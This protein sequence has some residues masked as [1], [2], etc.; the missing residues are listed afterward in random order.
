MMQ[1]GDDNLLDSIIY[2]STLKLLFPI[3][4]SNR[5][6]VPFFFFDKCLKFGA[7]MIDQPHQILT[8]TFKDAYQ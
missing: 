7:K 8:P 3:F 2:W 5:E 1:E 6:Y 4:F